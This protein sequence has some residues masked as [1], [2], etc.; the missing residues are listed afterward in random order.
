MGQTTTPFL[1]GFLVKPS[2]IS[3]LGRVTY[4]DGTND[5][6][7]NQLQ[8]E[9]YGYTYNKVTGT[10]STFRYNSN[11]DSAVANENN[12]TFGSNNTTETGSNN[13]LVMGES[14]TIR[15]LSRNNSIIGIQNVIA[16][17]VNNAS[18]S[19]TL[20]EAT[21]SGSVVLG[22]NTS[23]DILGER[24]SVKCIYGAQTTGTTTVAS[25]IN[26]VVNTRFVI[27][28]NTIVYF[29]ADTV[30]VR[31]GG[32]NVAGAVGDYGSYVERGVII[33]KSGV[34]SIQRERDT[35]KTSGTVTNWRILAAVGADNTL[36]FTCRGQ[37]N[38]ILEWCMNVNITQLKTGVTL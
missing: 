5:V 14:N 18:V 28:D 31:T 17:G 19:G 6:I 38:M 2:S 8:C 36:S 34:L 1:S 23:G 10:C 16:Y 32:T 35:I 11:L 33:N 37:T 30:V 13:A 21:A 4:T 27:P 7:P 15:G 12:K 25:G 20:G 3:V 24:Q 22:G 26:N 9:A 29:H